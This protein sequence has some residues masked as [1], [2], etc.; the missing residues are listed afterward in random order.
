VR[1]ALAA[2]GVM[3]LL[4][5]GLLFSVRSGGTAGSRSGRDTTDSAVWRTQEVPSPPG[6]DL[7]GV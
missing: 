5:L 6:T 2:T 3:V 7:L 1:G 4:V